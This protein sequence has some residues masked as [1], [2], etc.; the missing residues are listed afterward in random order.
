MET[1]K[2]L[3]IDLVS[4]YEV[5][6]KFSDNIYRNHRVQVL[7]SLT[8]S[9]LAMRIFL[10]KFYGH[11]IPLINKRSVHDEIRE[12]Y[13]GGITEVYKPYGESLYYYDV[14]SLYPYA[15]LNPMPGINCVFADTI[16][17]DIADLFGFYYCTIEAAENY[18]GLLP[19][20]NKEGVTM[21]NGQ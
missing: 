15:A 5:M 6:A 10:S 13:F 8:I 18:L 9:S 19:V 16:T 7:G 1:F 3:E 2:Y 11:D 20:R 4:L 14:N 12:S 21:P 17:A